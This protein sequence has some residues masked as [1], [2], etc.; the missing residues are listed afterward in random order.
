MSTNVFP[1]ALRR[2]AATVATA[3]ALTALA[4]A[5]AAAHDELLSTTPQEGAVLET[6]P[7][8]IEL[9]FSGAIMD[10]GNEVRVTDSTGQSVAAGEP[11]L[12][13]TRVI[14]PVTDPA[15]ED[16]TYRV[17]WRVVSSD[18]HPI[19]GTF[20]YEVGDGADTITTPGAGEAPAA[21]DNAEAQNTDAE[22]SSAGIPMWAV[23]IAGAAMALAVV[24]LAAWIAR[25]RQG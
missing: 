13:G 10:I 21:P 18:G 8:Q 15:A 25:R 2:A 9:T 6:A 11:E 16:E 4:A 1:A 20:S 17:V 12:D 22:N 7:E 23:G 19:D 5:P 14:Q 24:G 3:G